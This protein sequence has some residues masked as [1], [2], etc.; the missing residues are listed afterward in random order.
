MVR[1]PAMWLGAGISLFL[2]LWNTVIVPNDSKTPSSETENYRNNDIFNSSSAHATSD[3]QSKLKASLC[4]CVYTS[5]RW[6]C[7]YCPN[8]NKSTIFNIKNNKVKKKKKDTSILL[9]APCSVPSILI[10]KSWEVFLQILSY[11]FTYRYLTL[12]KTLIF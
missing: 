12:F 9:P 4:C 5:N 6:I 11:V 10:M 3:G 8:S 2:Y 7:T 1:Q